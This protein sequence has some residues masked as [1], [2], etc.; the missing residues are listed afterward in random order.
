MTPWV[1]RLL[2]ANVVAY[3]VTMNSPGLLNL[4]AFQ[5]ASILREP[6]TLLTY[7]FVHDLGGIRHI[8][9]NMLSLYF[10]GPAVEARLGSSRF[11]ALYLVSGLVGAAL[12]FFTPA[13]Y[14][15]GA[16]GAIFGVMFA[17]ASFFPHERIYVWGVLPIQARVFV[18]IMTVMS[19]LGAGGLFDPG[20]AHWAH[21]GGFV[22]GWLYLKWSEWRSP[23]ATFRRRVESFEHPA[24]GNEMERW[25]RISREGLHALNLEELDR[26]RAKIR[27]HGLR[28]L[29][30]EERAFL[31]RL[32]LRSSVA[33]GPSGG[34][35][36]IA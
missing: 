14:I 34:Q 4:L 32:S 12:S 25:A 3:L 35:S 36:G 18:L 29:T 11:I 21:L 1:T 5:P 13:A 30:A 8:L 16:S 26:V 22:G 28:S 9:F 20:T 6:W 27:E 33:R 17:F 19:L 31:D 2:I 23:R 7:M 10:F 24:P 15:I